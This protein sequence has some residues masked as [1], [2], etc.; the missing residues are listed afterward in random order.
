MPHVAFGVVVTPLLGCQL[1]WD[2]F[3]LQH[4][5]DL[6]FAAACAPPGGGRHI[7]NPRLLKHF[8]YVPF[9]TLFYLNVYTL[10]T[11]Q[12]RVRE[13]V[14]THIS[15]VLPHWNTLQLDLWAHLHVHVWWCFLS[16]FCLCT[17]YVRFNHNFS[18]YVTVCWRYR[19]RPLVVFSIFIRYS[20]ASFYTRVTLYQK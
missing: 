19:L 11:P 5:T 12:Y 8:W 17:Y 15:Q 13:S 16:N 10:H 20:S 18:E 7:T 14:Y 3:V 6:T 4:T 9:P 2:H 1:N